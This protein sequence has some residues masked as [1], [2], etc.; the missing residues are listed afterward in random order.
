MI[1]TGGGG[2]DGNITIDGGG[3][4][5]GASYANGIQLLAD[6]AQVNI[7]A[8]TLSELDHLVIT[9]SSASLGAM[10]LGDGSGNANTALDV[11][12]TG[13][14]SLKGDISTTGE[15]DAG[16]VSLA[17]TGQILL[18]SSA[19]DTNITINTD[20]ALA[21]TDRDI[22]LGTVDATT[23]GV[24]GLSLV[25]GGGTITL[26]GDVGANTYLDN[27]SATGATV[28]VNANIKA[29]NIDLIGTTAV[30]IDT[31]AYTL[32]VMGD[33]AGGQGDILVKSDSQAFNAGISFRVRP[34]RVPRP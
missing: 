12:T 8:T 17:A 22:T 25:A 2:T 16:N 1:N 31:A 21:G 10:T 29:E 14:I 28:D 32:D 15:T 11:T 34:V 20:A 6:T 33:T 30:A 13:N 9:A 24:E 23:E 19:G 18:D 27:F 4:V 3:T 26:N 5:D 7:S